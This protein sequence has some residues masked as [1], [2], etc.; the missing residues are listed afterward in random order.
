MIE[1]NVSNYF[2]NCKQ[3]SDVG[4]LCYMK[5]LKDASDKVLYVLYGFETTQN[6]KNSDK[7]TL[8][9]P[10]H[11]CVQQFCSK[12]EDAENCGECLRCGQRKHSFWDDPVGVLL[13]YLRQPRPWANNVV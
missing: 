11:V 7:A 6:T 5:P 8:H 12:C 13:L 1:T 4:H 10:D 2:A 9:V 3:N